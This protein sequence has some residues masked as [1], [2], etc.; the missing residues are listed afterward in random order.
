MRF[1]FFHR[2]TFLKC[3]L[4]RTAAASRILATPPCS[5][6]DHVGMCTS[7]PPGCARFLRMFVRCL[8]HANCS[9]TRPCVAAPRAPTTPQSRSAIIYVC[10]RFITGCARFSQHWSRWTEEESERRVTDCLCA[11][12]C[13]SVRLVMNLLTGCRRPKIT[14]CNHL[15]GEFIVCRQQCVL[16]VD[17]S[18]MSLEA[19]EARPTGSRN[20]GG[21]SLD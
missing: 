15:V 6:R 18:K 3:A 13:L 8:R 4:I 20:P 17:E 1:V 21:S 16:C 10:A 7:Y 14:D 11:S 19:L 9:V 2:I 5:E 12:S